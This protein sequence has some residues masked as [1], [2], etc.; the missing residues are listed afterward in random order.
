VGGD[1]GIDQ[2]LAD[3]PEALEGTF[4]VIPHK[5]TVTGC[6]GREDRR[7]PPVWPLDCQGFLLD[8]SRPVYAFSCERQGMTKTDV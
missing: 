5:P 3:G 2:L 4:L 6:I 1:Y 8:W 7:Q